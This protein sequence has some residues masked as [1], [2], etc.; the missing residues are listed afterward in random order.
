MQLLKRRADLVVVDLGLP[1][2]DGLS[3]VK[4]LA[5]QEV[6]VV[7]LTARGELQSRIDGLN[8]GAL[9]YFVKPADLTE[10]VA[11]ILSQLR[12]LD[13]APARQT[14]TA[15]PWRLKVASAQLFAPDQQVA[16][17]TTRE[18]D[19]VPTDPPAPQGAR[20]YGHGAA[21]AGGVW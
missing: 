7:V 10:L 9:Q 8:A 3:F 11:G 5:Q 15:L 19:R 17:R 20:G 12:R 16:P 6:P 21:G 4:R 13:L 14:G 18:L 2:E 1:G